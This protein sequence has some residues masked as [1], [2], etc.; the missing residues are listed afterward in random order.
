L[1]HAFQSFF[2]RVQDHLTPGYPRFK[3]KGERDSFRYPQGVRIEGHKAWLP[4]IGWVRFRK[5]REMM[6]KIKQTTLEIEKE[7]VRA[8]GNDVVGIDLGLEHFVTVAHDMAFT[9]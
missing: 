4:K 9:R 8:N 5:S 1:N 7:V 3:R 2:Q 6:G